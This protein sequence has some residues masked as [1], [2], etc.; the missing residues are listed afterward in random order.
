M[1]N[2]P[3]LICHRKLWP[4]NAGLRWVLRIFKMSLLVWT[5][6]WIFALDMR[7]QWVALMATTW[8]FSKI[9]VSLD[10]QSYAYHTTSLLLQSTHDLV[11]P[12]LWCQD[13][14][15]EWRLEPIVTCC[16][17]CVSICNKLQGIVKSVLKK[18]MVRNKSMWEEQRSS[19]T[20]RNIT[21]NRLP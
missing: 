6:N 20:Q 3:Y 8:F 4:E 21:R 2:L 14:C 12:L 9:H 1:S 10:T 11:Q 7:E 19:S 15:N 13:G 5:K 17:K 16:G 18:S